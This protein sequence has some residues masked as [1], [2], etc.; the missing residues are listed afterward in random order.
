MKPGRNTRLIALPVLSGPRL[1]RNVAPAPCCCSSST[2]RGTPSRVPRYVSTSI[3]SA[4]FIECAAPSTGDCL[5]HQ[6]LCISN[7]R[8]VRVENVLER[9]FHI[10]ARF[11]LELAAGV[12]DLRYP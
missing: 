10:H 3:L 4:S 6:P 1:K 2:R 9:G 11:P 5:V 8:A 12:G 7:V